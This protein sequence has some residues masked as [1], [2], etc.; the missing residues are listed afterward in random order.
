M[1]N[2]ESPHDADKRRC[3]TNK[4]AARRAVW[5]RPEP[6]PVTTGICVYGEIQRIVLHGI[7]ERR[8]IFIVILHE[9]VF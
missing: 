3:N 4:D 8:G 7:S 2:A 6:G 9:I 1:Q 5:E